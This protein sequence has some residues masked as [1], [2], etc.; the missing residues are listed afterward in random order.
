M[1]SLSNLYIEKVLSEHPISTWVLSDDLGYISLIS[2][3]NR[4]NHDSGQWE[5]TNATSSLE[6]FPPVNVPFSSSNTSKI[7]GSVPSLSTMTIDA[8]SVFTLN[9]SNINEDFSSIT[10]GFFIYIDNPY[11]RSISVGYEY[12]NLGTLSYVKNIK[13][14]D[15]TSANSDSWIFVSGTFN[16]PTVAYEDIKIVIEMDTISGGTS[17]DY[18]FYINGLTVGQWSEEF[19]L[20]SLGINTESIPTNISLP[21]T[22]KVVPAKQYSIN[23]SNAYYLSNDSTLFAKNFGIPLAYGSSN[24]T[25]I[26][27][28]VVGD[29]TYPSLIFPGS[30]FLNKRGQY[31]T[32]TAEMWIRLNT[33]TN[34]PRKIFGPISDKNGLY[35][36]GSFLTFVIGNNIGSHYIGE[37]SRPML[38]DI[39]FIKN[40]ISVL[41]NGEQ[42]ININI[43]ENDLLFP[44]EFDSNGKSQDWLGF[45]TY[46]DIGLFEID[47]FSLY[48]YSV[49]TEVAKRRWVWGQG[50][51][52]PESTNYSLNAKTA[53]NDYSFANYSSNYNYPNFAN[54]NQGFFS[55]ID[56]SKELLK[57][58]D[59]KLPEF[60]LDNFSYDKWITDIKD[61]QEANATKYFTFRP[62]EDWDSKNCYIFFK[63]MNIINENL[64][65][66]YGVF[67]S[68]TTSNN[69]TLFKIVNNVT[70]D[71]LKCTINGS[72]ITYSINLSGAQSVIGTKTIT[73]NV[74]FV[75]GIDIGKLSNLSINGIRSFFA[76]LSNLSLY[77]GGEE[78][79][80]YTGLML[81]FSFDAEY[82]SKKINTSSIDSNGLFNINSSIGNTIAQHTANYTL[83]LLY[84]YDILF[85]DIASAGYWEDYIPLSYFAKTTKNYEGKEYYDLDSIQ[86][87]LDYPEP[88]ERSSE[89]SVG[90]WTYQ[91]LKIRYETLNGFQY[92]QT[93]GQLDNNIYSGWEDY[94]DMSE[95]SEKYYNFN[96]ENNSIKSYISFQ[97]ITN[98]SNKNL[99]DFLS[100]EIAPVSGVIEPD[101]S[102]N[103]WEDTAFEVFDGTIIYAPS[104]NKNLATI[105]FNNYA[106]V[107]HLDFISD[108]IFH[109]PLKFKS[110]QYASKVLERNDFSKMGT[111][112]GTNLYLYRKTGTYYDFKGH[113]PVATYKGST[114]HLFL[115]NN[116]GWKLK[117]EASTLIERGLSMPVNFEKGINYKVSSIQMWLRYSERVFPTVGSLM[118]SVN[119]KNSI[120]DFYLEGDSSTQRGYV[121][122]ID[123]YSGNPLTN[124][125]YSINGNIVDTPYIVNENW[126]VLGIGFSDLLDFSEYSGTI[127]VTGNI[128]F[129]NL[130]YYLSDDLQ[131]KQKIKSRLWSEV[132]DG[133]KTWTYWETP[134]D[135]NSDGDYSDAGE[136]DGT[137]R[138]IYVIEDSTFYNINPNIV[139]NGYVGIDRIIVDDSVNGI[140]VD[141]EKFKVYSSPAWSTFTKT[142]A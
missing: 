56:T 137:W 85:V 138:S 118:L 80:T 67:K 96:T 125:I 130:S 83:K 25:K 111:K 97:K 39:R 5:L 46:S 35:A 78:S 139:Y 75:C 15:V 45:Y 119:H 65:M 73:A 57:I 71:Y 105:D 14:V 63:N 112:F 109:N 17:G 124:V 44:S 92:V 79:N 48:S 126:S 101:S 27:E 100:V 90:F 98:G 1:K 81:N 4:K 141:P 10:I 113:N 32:Y 123:R 22:F 93:Y 77:I 87:N 121:Y 114:P 51:L 9:E 29:V 19:N 74:N 31:N 21:N 88:L 104:K 60:I 120:Y 122:G 68:D 28:N 36:D 62:S 8:K 54:W 70:K 102:R 131:Q 41:L 128:T 43:N 127:N 18:N 61:S 89:E 95:D 23:Q 59:Y 86:I 24:V 7:I 115:N 84:K 136:L 107:T 72:T 42:V 117:G 34:T 2:E 20:K 58:P 55:N 13:T 40:N 69:E 11:T 64:K 49:P 140:M 26:Y 53:Y 135:I 82:N 30:G 110:L 132:K 99:I 94:Q 50:I 103:E 3:E 133:S 47:S 129:N 66:F 52:P 16:L 12:Y 76:T 91:D 116:S 134:L 108:G 6:S 38:I 33:D 106:I 37:W 142:P